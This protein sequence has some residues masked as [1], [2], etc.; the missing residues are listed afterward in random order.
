MVQKMKMMVLKKV[1]PQM[2]NTSLTLG[3]SNRPCTTPI[4]QESSFKKTVQKKNH[5]IQRYTLVAL[6]IFSGV[7]VINTNQ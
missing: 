6:E 3:S 1:K 5:Q 2:I 4:F 7:L